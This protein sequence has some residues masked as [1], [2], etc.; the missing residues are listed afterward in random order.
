MGSQLWVVDHENEIEA[1]RV[2]LSGKMKRFI[3]AEWIESNGQLK[4]TDRKR[5]KT[6]RRLPTQHNQTYC[7]SN[8]SHDRSRLVGDERNEVLFP[9]PQR[10]PHKPQDA[11]IQTF[12]VVTDLCW[13]RASAGLQVDRAHRVENLPS[14][15][16]ASRRRKVVDPAPVWLQP[17][18]VLLEGL[19]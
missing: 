1:M 12:P 15:S 18:S 14:S 19:E 7:V 9:T 2:R 11:E 17:R 6:L 3:G 10:I 16:V 5:Q 8:P 4:P 13:S